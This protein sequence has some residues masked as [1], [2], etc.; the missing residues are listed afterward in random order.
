MTTPSE[1][2]LGRG[3]ETGKNEAVWE[4]TIDILKASLA[5]KPDGLRLHNRR[6]LVLLSS[7]IKPKRFFSGELFFASVVETVRRNLATNTTDPDSLTMLRARIIDTVVQN[8]YYADVPLRLIPQVMDGTVLHADA[9]R[10]KQKA[11]ALRRASGPQSLPQTAR[12]LY[13]RLQVKSFLLASAD[14]S[15]NSE[16]SRNIETSQTADSKDILLEGVLSTDE[17][18]GFLNRI[19]GMTGGAAEW[20]GIDIPLDVRKDITKALEYMR[21]QNPDIEGQAEL[22]LSKL[23]QSLRKF[24]PGTKL[25]VSNMIARNQSKVLRKALHAFSRMKRERV[26]Q[27]LQS[28]PK[29][30]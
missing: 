26:E 21:Q 23:V 6:S 3:T 14:N 20:F 30:R 25:D 17:A 18:Y 10:E 8:P 19:H 9:M 16:G 4:K 29:K 22:S 11:Q 12:D 15:Q 13:E 24:A 7:R 5:V 28:I 27:F 2:N 1:R